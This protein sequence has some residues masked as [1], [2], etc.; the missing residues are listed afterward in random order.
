MAEIANGTIQNSTIKATEY[1]NKDVAK[2]LKKLHVAFTKSRS[3][4]QMTM[5]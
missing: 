1:N 2:L 4:D 3:I 5:P